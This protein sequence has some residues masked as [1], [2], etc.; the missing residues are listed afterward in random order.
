MRLF[1]RIICHRI[2]INLFCPTVKMATFALRSDGTSL[3]VPDPSH[4]KINTA[5]RAENFFGYR[6]ESECPSRIRDFLRALSAGRLNV[7][8]SRIYPS[9]SATA[10]FNTLDNWVL[11][12]F[13]LRKPKQLKKILDVIKFI[14]FS[15]PF[16]CF[17]TPLL[18]KHC[19]TSH[20]KMA[21][22][23]IQAHWA[24]A[25]FST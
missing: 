15:S 23:L 21:P 16:Q 9:L 3:R 17:P 7:F 20:I 25:N 10:L 18:T 8:T 5:P 14:F 12:S 11:W 1:T 4:A 2:P 22:S 24:M 6:A 19:K 13:D